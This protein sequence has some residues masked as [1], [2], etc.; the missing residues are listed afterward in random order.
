MTVLIDT[1]VVS[2][3]LRPSLNPAVESWVT[4][5]PAAELHFSAVG[6]SE[7]RYGVA[8]LPAGWLRKGLAL[9]IDAIL[10]EDLEGRIPPFDSDAA[11]EYAATAAARRSAGRPV[12]P[13]DCRVAAIARSRGIAVA[14]RNVP[15]FREI[16]LEIVDPWTAA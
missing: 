7:L 9:A 11:H 3:I 15:D 10:R 1:N 2:E 12:A 4:E 8:I 16:E 14:T 5:R 13:A 6:E